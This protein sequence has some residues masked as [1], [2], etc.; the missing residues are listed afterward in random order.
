MDERPDSTAEERYTILGAIHR[1]GMGEILL[2]RA[3]GADG[4]NKKI[5]LKGLLPSLTSDPVSLEL[6]RREARLMARL[7]H[8][9]I[10]RVLD[11]AYVHEQPYLAM[12]YVRGRNLH[13][14]IQRAK[15]RGERL[16]PRYALHI[17][18]EAL[19]GI[20]HAH[21]ARDE[22]GTPL[23]I[24]HRDVSPGNI[25]L[26]FFGEVKVTDF[27]IAK[28]IG[29]RS[30]TGPRSIRGKAR[31]AAPE[32]I[33]GESASPR[34]DLY[35]AGVVLAEALTGEPLW[36]KRGVSQTL[37]QIVSEPRD[38]TLERI[39]E[40]IPELPGLRTVLRRMLAL[41]PDDRF[42]AAI[43]AADAIDAL[44]RQTAG[45]DELERVRLGSTPGALSG[46]V[47][48]NELGA[49]I[50]RLFDDAP[51]LPR[52]ICPAPS[53]SPPVDFMTLPPEPRITL[54]S[55]PPDE[56]VTPWD[57]GKD[58]KEK[59]ETGERHVTGTLRPP[60]W[61]TA[62]SRRTGELPRP[63]EEPHTGAPL[64]PQLEIIDDFEED[65]PRALAPETPASQPMYFAELLS[66]GQT[67]REDSGS[68][69][70]PAVDRIARLQARIWLQNPWVLIIV[71]I[72][73][74]AATAITGSLIA[75]SS[76]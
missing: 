40:N 28:A 5:V 20:D 38:K 39:F 6:F 10:V 22:D 61:L 76:R 57:R 71:G 73:I 62:S 59:K 49:C 13:Q 18:A 24:I 17:L 54:P 72:L 74:G 31:Y 75:L 44:I 11:F 21:R 19:R 8:P 43:E 7:E 12:E 50:R 47:S 42:E 34:S 32:V 45:Q 29:T 58:G 53:L 69:S 60:H 35:A 52:D 4:F 9:N 55:P 65:L 51:D 2:A 56:E 27:G 15:E 23:G 48:S 64:R 33:R 14:L 68:V 66:P 67:A 41:R 36:E 3:A 1:G 25:L 16:P 37:I 26:S 63:S 30:L 70:E 46:A